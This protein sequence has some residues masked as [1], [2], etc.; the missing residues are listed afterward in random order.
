[1]KTLFDN[2]F[3]YTNDALTLEDIVTSHLKHVFKKHVEEGF[4]PR[5]ISLIMQSAI[6]MLEMEAVMNRNQ[7]D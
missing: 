5:E 4:S 2:N 1:M 6:A 3:R 7:N